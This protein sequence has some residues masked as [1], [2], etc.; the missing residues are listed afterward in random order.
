V[1][2]WASAQE[3]MK[4]AHFAQILGLIAAIPAI[5]TGFRDSINS[6]WGQSLYDKQT[7]QLRPKIKILAIHTAVTII[8]TLGHLGIFYNRERVQST[9]ASLGQ[10][11]PQIVALEAIF[12]GLM[13]FGAGLGGK[14]AFQF[15]M[16]AGVQQKK[17]KSQ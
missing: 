10:L 2:Q 8:A 11:D 7:K 1:K 3:I 4:A 12:C 16:G 15:G 13:F 17:N 9:W 5:A 6:L 14:L